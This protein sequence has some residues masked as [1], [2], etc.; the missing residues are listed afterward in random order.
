MAHAAL[1]VLPQLG[2]LRVCRP[3][4]GQPGVTLESP[5]LL[6]MTDLKRVAAALISPHETMDRA[7]AFM[8]QRGVRMLLALDERQNLAGII[9]TKDLVVAD[10]A[11]L[12]PAQAQAQSFAEIEAA[13]A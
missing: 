10:A 2:T 13:L 3:E 5:A 6:V 8:V 1:P 4:Q 11:L 9:T 7:H 12:L